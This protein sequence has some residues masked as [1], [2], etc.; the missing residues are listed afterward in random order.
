MIT[1]IDGRS[2]DDPTDVVEV[3][4]RGKPGDEVEVEFERG[5]RD[6]TVTVTLG[7][8]PARMP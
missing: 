5:G 7:T 1:S 3:V 6:Q 4:S 8:R 2:I